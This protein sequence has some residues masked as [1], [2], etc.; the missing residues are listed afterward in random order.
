MFLLLFVFRS[1]LLLRSINLNQ[2]IEASI[3]QCQLPGVKKL[4][5]SNSEKKSGKKTKCNPLGYC[6]GGS[7]IF[8]FTHSIK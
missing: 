2:M 8:W 5:D 4:W 7:F 6:S 3:P 1:P